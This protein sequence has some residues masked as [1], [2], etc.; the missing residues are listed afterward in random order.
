M[1]GKVCIKYEW[2]NKEY[3]FTLED[4]E[5]VEDLQAAV[6]K[7]L[8]IPLKHDLIVYNEDGEKKYFEDLSSGMSIRVFHG[9]EYQSKTIP[10]KNLKE[11][12][13]YNYFKTYWNVIKLGLG[14]ENVYQ[15]TKALRSHGDVIRIRS[16]KDTAYTTSNPKI[17][18]EITSRNHDFEKIVS[19]G[20]GGMGLL[21]SETCAKDGLLTASTSE[22]N[23]ALAHRI[24]M[25]LFS[26]SNIRPMTDNINNEITLLLKKIEDNSKAE[27]Q[28]P[29]ARFL[30][31]STFEMMGLNFCN[32][33]FSNSKDIQKYSPLK[34]LD[35]VGKFMSKTTRNIPY[36]RSNPLLLN[37]FRKT[38]KNFT[39]F[40]Y[41]VITKRQ[42]C[43]KANKEVPNDPLTVILTE[44]DK[45]T[46]KKLPLENVAAQLSTF[47][48]AGHTTVTSL[49][50]FVLYHLCSHPDVLDKLTAEIDATLGDENAMSWEQAEGM[51]YMKCVLQ[52]TLRVTPPIVFI[53]KTALKNTT[54]GNNQYR[55]L[56]GNRL[57][58]DIQGMHLSKHHF[59]EDAEAFRPERWL[60]KNAANIDAE[61]FRPFGSGVRACIGFQLA[62]LEGRIILARLLHRFRPKFASKDYR[63]NIELFFTT[64]PRNLLLNFVKRKTISK[65]KI[66]PS[67]KTKPEAASGKQKIAFLYGSNMG[68]SQNY[69][70]KIA[71]ELGTIG[72]EPLVLTLDNALE[73]ITVKN[74]PN[75]LICPTYNG[76]P[77]ENAAIFDDYLNNLSSGALEGVD[78]SIFGC[79]NSQWQTTFQHFPKS[80]SDRLKKSGANEFHKRGIGNADEDIEK[81]FE[82]WKNS[83]V[84][85]IKG[86]YP[87]SGDHVS[88]GDNKPKY[89]VD[90]IEHMD[91]KTP[92]IVHGEESHFPRFLSLHEK[93]L[94]FKIKQK[95]NLCSNNAGKEVYHIELD[96]PHGENYTAGDH[97]GVMPHNPKELI[98]R[99]ANLCDIE[100]QQ[101][102]MFSYNGHGEPKVPVNIPITVEQVLATHLD[103]SGLVSRDTLHYFLEKIKTPTEQ[104]RIQQLAENDYQQKVIGRQLNIIEILEGISDITVSLADL[105][106]QLHVLKPR[107]YSIS[108]SSLVNSELCSITVGLDENLRDDGKKILG[109][110]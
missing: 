69:V 109:L 6:V 59:G 84:S 13:T 74:I 102:I 55:I 25:P 45:I 81:D 51:V 26:A 20:Y 1:K 83:L 48:L 5:T 57:V 105:V 9:L 31:E 14:F 99:A 73:Q 92:Q 107:Y 22:E 2:Q 50:S 82:T 100:L 76:F 53:G 8:N 94:N 89:V 90:I 29:I 110:C 67:E 44:V 41:N 72:Y 16:Y 30:R 106:I 52:E 28:I 75:V 19:N 88:K 87:I 23:W 7:T 42:T 43:I 64:L 77:P 101:L 4:Y 3:F 96:L 68:R 12:Y 56:K 47:L 95:H 60:P 71:D 24:M 66:V 93:R 63:L 86:L 37:K 70:Y 49:C 15:F 79:G 58:V 80:V 103:L 34:D 18:S 11:P 10:P 78:F 108:S 62:L 65:S 85:T 40:I 61:A 36:I 32:M 54:F 39:E 46:E 17:L 97:L 33:K 91:P 35:Y 98:Q 27:Q 21:K 104:G 38:S